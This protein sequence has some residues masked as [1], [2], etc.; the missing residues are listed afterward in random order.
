M[1]TWLFRNGTGV[2]V[3]LGGLSGAPRPHTLADARAALALIRQTPPRPDRP[4]DS[5]PS[6][7]PQPKVPKSRAGILAQARAVRAERRADRLRA[8]QAAED[9]LYRRLYPDAAP[10]QP[11][12]AAA[13]VSEDD[14]LYDKLYGQP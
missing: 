1:S 9:A 7:N 8:A 4:E 2:G 6:T 5:M 13:P 11:R 10:A 3:R 12:Y 14:R